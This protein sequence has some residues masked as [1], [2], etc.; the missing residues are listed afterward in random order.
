MYPLKLAGWMRRFGSWGDRISECARPLLEYKDNKQAESR[1]GGTRRLRFV[2]MRGGTSLKHN[3]R[4][5]LQ[6]I[7]AAAITPALARVGWA[8]GWPAK[9][10]RVIIP[11][12]AGSTTALVAR[13]A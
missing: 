5:H 12:S 8:Q 2:P 11:F 3:R 6:L 9:P 1:T 7:A 10:I 4:R 13:I